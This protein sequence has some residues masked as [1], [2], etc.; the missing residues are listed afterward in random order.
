MYELCSVYEYL[1]RT[2]VYIVRNAFLAA[3]WC[4]AAAPRSTSRRDEREARRSRSAQVYRDRVRIARHRDPAMIRR[5]AIGGARWRCPHAPI[6]HGHARP[7]A[8]PRATHRTPMR[9]AGCTI[10]CRLRCWR[11]GVAGPRIS[12]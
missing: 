1:S 10:A 5:S 3:H 4:A 7:A 6:A 11:A 8:R 12:R 2:N 9:H